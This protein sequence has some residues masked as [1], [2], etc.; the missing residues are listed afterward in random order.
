MVLLCLHLGADPNDRDPQ[1]DTALLKELKSN[2][3]YSSVEY[4]QILL[5][6]GADPAI[7]DSDSGNNALHLLATNHNTNLFLAFDVYQACPAAASAKNASDFAPYTVSIMSATAFRVQSQTAWHFQ[8]H[9]HFAGG[10]E[11]WKLK[12]GK[13]LLRCIGLQYAPLPRS[14]CRRRFVHHQS[15]LPNPLAGPPLRL[16]VLD[17]QLPAGVAVSLPM[18]NSNP[19]RAL[20]HWRVLGRAYF[21]PR[22]LLGHLC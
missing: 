5:H 4:I 11:L 8:R 22:G 10:S 9:H 3:G 17:C 15:L 21:H 1:G 12:N 18:V 2:A 20:L 19:Q 7:K 16:R 13:V 6:F 14:H